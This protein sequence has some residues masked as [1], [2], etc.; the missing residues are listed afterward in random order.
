MLQES[1]G[2]AAGAPHTQDS[3]RHTQPGVAASA[4][5]IQAAPHTQ[6]LPDQAAKVWWAAT[7]A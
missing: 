5:E 4:N 6:Q 3:V 7:W 1:A 2:Q